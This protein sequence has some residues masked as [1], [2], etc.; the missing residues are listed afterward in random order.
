MRE[1]LGYIPPKPLIAA[2]RTGRR[3]RRPDLQNQPVRRHKEQAETSAGHFPAFAA[4]KKGPK[5]RTLRPFLCGQPGAAAKPGCG[6]KGRGAAAEPERGGRARARAARAGA[7]RQNRGAGGKGRGADGKGRGAAAELGRS[8]RTGRGG[9]TGA[10]TARARARAARAGARRQE[11]GRGRQEPGRGGKGLG[12][13]AEQERGRQQ[14]VSR[15]RQGR[16]GARNTT[17]KR[18]GFPRAAAPNR[19]GPYPFRA[20]ITSLYIDWSTRCASSSHG[21]PSI[22]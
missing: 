22:T 21:P 2:D 3:E 5:R 19:T 4:F 10:R 18:P 11:L 13:A 7:R 14:D 20:T 8:G 6:G 15:C 17:R 1:G 9:R 12:A 16:G